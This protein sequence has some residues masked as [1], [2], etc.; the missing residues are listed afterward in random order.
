MHPTC[1]EKRIFGSG[2]YST[3]HTVFSDLKEKEKRP[4]KMENTTRTLISNEFYSNV[5]VLKNRNRKTSY[6]LASFLK[7]HTH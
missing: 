5:V 7:A 2:N 3:V 1:R 6:C 4:V